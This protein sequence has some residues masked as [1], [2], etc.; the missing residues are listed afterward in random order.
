MYQVFLMHAFAKRIAKFRIGWL[1]AIITIFSIDINAQFLKKKV[2]EAPS[3]EFCE[4]FVATAT[5]KCSNSEYYV[6][7]QL[8][9]SPKFKQG[10]YIQADHL[11]GYQGWVGNSFVD[12]PFPSGTGFSYTVELIANPN[13]A[14]NLNETTVECESQNVDLAEFKASETNKGNVISWSSNSETETDY[15][16]VMHSYDGKEKWTELGTKD[17]AG[18]TDEAQAYEI[19]DR[20]ATSGLSYYRLEAMEFNGKRR[21]LGETQTEKAEA[22]FE[23]TQVYPVP[24]TNYVNADFNCTLEEAI[25]S[26]YVI[27][28]YGR[29]MYESSM[30]VLKGENTIQ[31][32]M[33]DYDEGTYFLHLN[34]G[35]TSIK[36]RI[37]KE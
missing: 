23:F 32:D 21:R 34:E 7:L 20:Y 31:I 27:D 10:Y 16:I 5:Y 11:D 26:Y 9:G 3:R 18:S 17:A 4:D 33:T 25:I 15:F 14:F 12:G 2:K 30:E 13:C 6:N 37:I 28:P 8:A 22:I 19:T 29:M 35:G 1:I 36:S 24:T